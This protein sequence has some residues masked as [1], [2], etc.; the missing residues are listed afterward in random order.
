MDG[1]C[2]V[3]VMTGA[4]YQR[5]MTLVEVVIALILFALISLA[6]TSA[7]STMGQTLS[8]STARLDG[9]NDMRIISDFLRKTVGAPFFVFRPVDGQNLFFHGDQNQLYWVGNLS[10]YQ[11][12]GGLHLMH[13][14]LQPDKG[15]K[16]AALMLTYTRWYPDQNWVPDF[17]QA[18][19]QILMTGVTDFSIQYQTV[20]T[21]AAWQSQWAHAAQY[22]QA[23][24]LEIA[25]NHRHW[26]E[27]T[28]WLGGVKSAM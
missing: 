16:G 23:V 4:R 9:I 2:A 24:R 17:S 7:M 21:D 18:K 25:V 11:G 6:L 10:G 13:L 12:P 15:G 1:G 5:G 19:P 3:S 20:G 26:P 22:P 8:K 28:C 14:Y 27:I